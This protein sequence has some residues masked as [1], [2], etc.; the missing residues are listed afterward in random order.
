MIKE[1][2]SMKASKSVLLF[3][4]NIVFCFS[5]NATD[6]FEDVVENILPAAV[7]VESNN[8]HGSGTVLTS[9]GIIVTNLHVISKVTDLRVKLSNGSRYDEVKI[10]GFDEKNDLAIIKVNGSNLPHISLN[11]ISKAKIGQ[12]VYAL[13]APEGL[14]QTLSKGIVSSVRVFEGVEVIQTDAAISSGSSGGGLFS[15]NGALLGILVSYYKEGQN[16][17]FAIPAQLITPLINSPL[18]LSEE[19]F[20]KLD[21]NQDDS[22]NTLNAMA[23]DNILESF[24]NRAAQ[25]YNFEYA[26][27][28]KD[29]EYIGMYNDELPI[30]FNIYDDLLLMNL[31]LAIDVTPSQEQFIQLNKISINSN[32]SYI[33]FMD[34]VLSVYAEMPIRNV[35]YEAFESV[36]KGAIL[37][38]INSKKQDVI[39]QLIASNSNNVFSDFPKSLPDVSR[40]NRVSQVSSYSKRSLPGSM[41]FF[42]DNTRYNLEIVHE[43]ENELESMLTPIRHSVY[44][45]VISENIGE[46]EDHDE[47]LAMILNGYIENLKNDIEDI[48]VVAK[49]TRKING[50]N[51]VWAKYEFSDLGFRVKFQTSFFIIR[52]RGMSIHTWSTSNFSDTEK[53]M[54]KI[55]E[56]L[57]YTSL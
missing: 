6:R 18:A 51:S 33:G 52:G 43:S 23:S 49:G 30:L 29:N 48:E 47:A 14:E 21:F 4:F 8:G 32:Y 45:K 35:Q 9:D 11:R 10:L 27:N 57:E 46:P 20:F 17:N 54:V 7:V 39:A 5:V 24:L 53:E 3:I 25:E 31:P 15:Q 44:G 1:I 22:Y 56:T 13:G 40:N 12:T 28:D 55:L 41:A 38:H 26:P 50:E 2:E 16:L 42:Y 19:E 34:N 37:A 36:F